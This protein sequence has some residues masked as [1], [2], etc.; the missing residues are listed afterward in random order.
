MTV[1]VRGVV[2]QGAKLLRPFPD[3]AIDRS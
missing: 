2:L 3:F 1:T